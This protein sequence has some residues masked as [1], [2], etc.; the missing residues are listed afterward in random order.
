MTRFNMRIPNDT[1]TFAESRSEYMLGKQNVSAYI[2][3]LI[4]QDRIGN[5]KP[6]AKKDNPSERNA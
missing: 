2:L 4:Q 3:W 6:K 1:L 5:I